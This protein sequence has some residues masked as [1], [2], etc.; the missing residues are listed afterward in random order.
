MAEGELSW[1]DDPQVISYK[2]TE[3]KSRYAITLADEYQTA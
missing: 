2:T 3:G 1:A